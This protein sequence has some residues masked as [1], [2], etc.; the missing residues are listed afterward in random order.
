MITILTDFIGHDP[1]YSLCGVVANQVKM[2]IGLGYPVKVLVRPGF[3]DIHAYHG[4][5]IQ[6]ID[7]GESGDNTVRL[8][9]HSAEEIDSLTAQLTD[10]LHGTTVC[11]THDLLY[12][13]N[14][15]KYHVAARRVAQKL[16][17]LRWLHWVHST[18]PLATTEKTGPFQYELNGR[19]PNSRIVAF[20]RE[21][22]NRKGAMYGYEANQV[23]VIPSPIDFAEGWH[24]LT[25]SITAD[26][27]DYDAVAVY[28]CRLDRG[29]QPHIPLEIFAQLVGMGYKAHVIIVDFHST[30]D[31]KRD[32]RNE[33]REYAYHHN[34][35]VTF[36]SDFAPY[37][38]PHQVVMELFEFSDIFIHPS[39]NE[40]DGLVLME[41]AWKRCGLVLNFD[42]PRFREFD[43]LAVMG[44]F[45]SHIDT[46]TGMPGETKTGYGDRA[47]YMRQLAGAVAYN[48]RHNPTLQ[49]HARMRKERS[50]TAVS[51]LLWEAIEA[52]D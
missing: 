45:S 15:W 29:K 11:L 49:L 51:R 27:W 12:Q 26:L 46:H 4:A 52:H 39:M 10:A 33:M 42:L 43:G 3:L 22:V 21:E 7:P 34:V 30:G 9:P 8:S 23:V 40:A 5:D 19:F 28:P 36:T 50:L 20:H 2:L 32:Y 18:T 48:L 24:E 17:N 44:K 16:P 37:H 13:P 25:K 41:A 35:P 6:V 38:V 14:L 47:A 1:A 31:D